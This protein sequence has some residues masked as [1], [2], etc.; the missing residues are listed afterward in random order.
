MED[1]ELKAERKKG[2]QKKRQSSMRLSLN[3]FNWFEYLKIHHVI[4][5][6]DQ[7]NENFIISLFCDKVVLLKS[8][9]QK[10][11]KKKEKEK[12]FTISYE[13]E[14]CVKVVYDTVLETR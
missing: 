4:Q 7:V 14:S 9:C 3:L 5:S 6:P 12:I 10:R 13:P 1:P 8:I 2:I 11:K